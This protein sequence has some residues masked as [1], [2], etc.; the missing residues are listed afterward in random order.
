MN[1]FANPRYFLYLPV[2]LAAAL[3]V[4]WLGNLR[5]QSL[6][7]VLFGKTAYGKL[8]EDLRVVPLWRNGLFLSGIVFLFIALAGPQWGREI[9]Q[10][11]ALFAQTVIAVDVSASMRAQDLKPNR[12]ENAKQMLQMLINHLRDERIGIVAFTSEAFI[13]CPITTDIDALDYFV[14]ILRTDML[15]AVGTSIAAP[16]QTAAQM[17]AKYPGQKALILLTDG[18]DHAAEQLVTARKIAQENN[19]RIIAIGIGTPEGALIPDRIDNDGNVL[20]YKKDRTGKTVL[21]KLDEKTL[22]ELA[23][24]TGG[25][26]IAYTSPAKVARQVEA[27]LRGL[28]KSLTKASKHAVYKNRYALPLGLAILCFTGYLLWPLGRKT[29]VTSKKVQ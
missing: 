14:S 26:Y 20:D 4:I 8:T 29:K 3:L 1:L 12:L 27:S 6:I 28:D 21:S 18:E 15:P 2:L 23:K 9:V 7:R 19:I 24:D 17:L 25:A 13:Q 10:Q 11:E 22:V 5:K 16:V